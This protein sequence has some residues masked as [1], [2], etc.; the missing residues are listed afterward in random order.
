VTTGCGDVQS[1]SANCGACGHD[2][3][4][5]ACVAGVCQPVLLT[6]D[7]SFPNTIATDGVEVYW[8]NN[9][10]VDYGVPPASIV[11]RSMPTTGG[12]PKTLQIIEPGY[13]TSLHRD[14]QYLYFYK[15][16]D[17]VTSK[18]FTGSIARMCADGSC[19]VVDLSGQIDNYAWEL[20]LD[21]TRIYFPSS[22]N[23]G[24]SHIDKGGS[25][26][27]TAPM[28]PGFYFSRFAVDDAFVYAVVVPNAMLGNNA[29]Q[30]FVRLDKATLTPM[31]LMKGFNGYADVVV[32]AQN[33]FLADA[34]KVYRLPKTGPGA[35]VPTVITPAGLHPSFLASDKNRLY[36]LEFS[37]PSMSTPSVLHWIGKDGNGVGSITLSNEATFGPGIVADATSLYWVTTIAPL[38]PP[39]PAKGGIMKVVKPL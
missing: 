24:L 20:A 21:A 30:L 4:G 17:W 9:T 15:S 37:T 31:T 38:L 29:P 1:S 6:G 18:S 26:P 3:Q 2:C 25:V 16:V 12:A 19:P 23:G 36:W 14:G 22:G 33:I 8:A 5:G 39:V 27:T 32:D 35:L 28:F 34:D 13:P 11:V 7:E 10:N